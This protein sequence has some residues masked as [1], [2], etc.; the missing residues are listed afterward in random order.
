MRSSNRQ[1]PD[2]NVAGQSQTTQVLDVL[3]LKFLE[4]GWL[5][6]N[7]CVFTG[8]GPSAIVDTGYGSHQDQTLALLQ[9]ALGGR[10]LDLIVN[11]HL[12]SDHCGGNAILQAHYPSSTTLIPPGQWEAVQ[13]WDG[14]ALSYEPTGQ[15]CPRFAADERLM[16]GTE[17][18]LGP[19]QWQI[20]AAPGH[21]PHSVILFQPEYRVLISADALWQNGFGV[22]FPELEGIDAFDEVDATIDLIESLD[23]AI[24]IP[25]HGPLFTDIEPAI[26]R[27]RSRL[28]QFT[29]DPAL[30]QRYAAKVLIKYRLL[31]WQRIG[32]DALL[33]W[34]RRTPYLSTQMAANA[35]DEEAQ[36]EWLRDLLKELEKSGAVA[37]QGASV[38]NR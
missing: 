37:L 10:E 23:P 30:H 28:A 1:Q 35:T 29:N 18:R 19:L 17:I 32:F 5:S 15:L 16:P 13:Q 25:G 31:E 14:N 24:V 3:G 34:V 22:V 21:D 7:N 2:G 36:I 12:H 9:R 38:I 27:A 26:A 33:A 4:R 8:D 6:A 11:T 20:H